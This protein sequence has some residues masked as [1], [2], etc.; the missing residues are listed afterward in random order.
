[1]HRALDGA[2]EVKTL[3]GLVGLEA[4]QRF[5]HV[6][7]ARQGD[8]GAAGGEDDPAAPLLWGLEAE[9]AVD[10]AGQRDRRARIGVQDAYH[11]RTRLAVALNE[12][13]TER[14]RT[15]V[16]ACREQGTGDDRGKARGGEKQGTHGF[17]E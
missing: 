1:L 11:A 7:A 5:N 12:T 8:F 3:H 15:V 4:A 2:F 10:E 14:N 16:V 9:E 6:G 17:S 13:E